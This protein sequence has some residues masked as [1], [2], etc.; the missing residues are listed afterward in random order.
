MLPFFYAVYFLLFTFN[1][2]SIEH[3]F[4][5]DLSNNGLKAP[6]YLSTEET[7]LDILQ[8][9]ESAMIPYSEL[10]LQWLDSSQANLSSNVVDIGTYI[11]GLMGDVDNVQDKNRS[12]LKIK[13]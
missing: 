12:Y 7:K 1:L 5:E 13:L 10:Y 9:E 11:D 4:A 6:V 2:M 3:A 8:Q